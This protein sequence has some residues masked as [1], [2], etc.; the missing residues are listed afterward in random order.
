MQSQYYCRVWSVHKSLDQD[1]PGQARAGAGLEQV[2]H[3]ANPDRIR[4]GQGHSQSV[5][6]GQ[7]KAT[8]IKAEVG[9]SKSMCTVQ[10]HAQIRGT[11]IPT[12][13]MSQKPGATQQAK[14]VGMASASSITARSSACNVYSDD[15]F[16][17]SRARDRISQFGANRKHITK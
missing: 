6:A 4:Q 1:R 11:L 2:L 14:L 3:R 7:A 8:G 5:E 12:E 16:L 9:L 17:L 13:A 15:R 10:E